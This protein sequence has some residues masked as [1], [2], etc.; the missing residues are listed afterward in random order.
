V[1][2]PGDPFHSADWKSNNSGIVVIP[3]T[4]RTSLC[5]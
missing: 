1:L 5:N 3:K 4:R 2:L